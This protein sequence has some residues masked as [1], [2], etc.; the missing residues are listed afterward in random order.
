MEPVALRRAINRCKHRNTHLQFQ[1]FDLRQVSI[2]LKGETRFPRQE[3]LG[4]FVTTAAVFRQ[5][6]YSVCHPPLPYDNFRLFKTHFDAR[7]NLYRVNGLIQ[8]NL[9]QLQQGRRLIDSLPDGAYSRPQETV[10]Q[11]SIGD[12]FRHA[13][14]HFTAFFEGLESGI[15]DYEQR[16]RDRSLATDPDQA[17]SF[18]LEIETALEELDRQPE[19]PI[20]VREEGGSRDLP[21]SRDRELA[22][23]VS[24]TVHHFALIR[25]ICALERH[26]LP[27]D[28]GV[29]PST[30]RHLARS[31]R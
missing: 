7:M 6:E 10:F 11:S 21:T 30:L 31:S 14:D 18:S 4:P 19:R 26:P 22:F 1:F 2:R 20:T 17:R 29:A 28:F 16:R 8:Q 15:I 24:H 12:H 27:E 3:R 13:S 23:L 5:R 25:I 9:D